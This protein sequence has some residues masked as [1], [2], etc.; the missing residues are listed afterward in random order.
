MEVVNESRIEITQECEK[1]PVHQNHTMEEI[2]VIENSSTDKM[3]F[4]ESN[5]NFIL[6]KGCEVKTLLNK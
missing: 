1:T 6:E 4:G 5:N 2:D 3:T